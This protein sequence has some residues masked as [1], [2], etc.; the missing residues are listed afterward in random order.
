[1]NRNG[2]EWQMFWKRVAVIFYISCDK[3]FK[4][5]VKI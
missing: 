5:C 3:Y 2:Y 1:M 4:M